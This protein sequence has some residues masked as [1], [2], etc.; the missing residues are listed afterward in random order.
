MTV[1]CIARPSGGGALHSSR[2]IGGVGSCFDST[3][4]HEWRPLSGRERLSEQSLRRSLSRPTWSSKICG[5]LTQT[6]RKPISPFLS[7][8]HILPPLGDCGLFRRDTGLY[9][10]PHIDDAPGLT[11]TEALD[12]F[13]IDS[14]VTSLPGCWKRGRSNTHSAGR[15]RMRRLFDVRRYPKSLRLCFFDVTGRGGDP[16]PLRL[17]PS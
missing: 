7:P 1:E 13:G 16:P 2:A 6:G 14:T 12:A 4:P 17:F 11:A 8:E 5:R 15:P 9:P 3:P 10:G